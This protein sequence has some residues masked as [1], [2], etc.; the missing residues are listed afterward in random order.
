M[1]DFIFLIVLFVGVGMVY[2]HLSHD[3]NI[4]RLDYGISQVKAMSEN[5]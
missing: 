2:L 4:R 3:I 5:I 1:N